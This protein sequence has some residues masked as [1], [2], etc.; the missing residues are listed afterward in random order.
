[1]IS[2]EVIVFAM[3]LI[4]ILVDRGSAVTIC[5]PSSRTTCSKGV[6]KRANGRL[7]GGISEKYS[8][9]VWIHSRNALDD[10]KGN[11]SIW[12]NSTIGTFLVVLR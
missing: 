11:V 10:H 6:I 12:T 5:V 1:M 3:R 9:T 7:N 8:V 4:S 2:L